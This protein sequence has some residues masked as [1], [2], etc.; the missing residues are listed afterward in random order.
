M[1]AYAKGVALTILICA[2]CS[3]GGAVVCKGTGVYRECTQQILSPHVCVR[4]LPL[5]DHIYQDLAFKDRIA[6]ELRQQS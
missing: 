4:S 6:G 3:F 5:I 1:H 2:C